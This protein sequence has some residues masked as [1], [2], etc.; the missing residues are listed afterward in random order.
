MGN[1]EIRMVIYQGDS[2][3][4]LAVIRIPLVTQG[5]DQ[6][7]IPGGI[8]LEF[9]PSYQKALNVVP[10]DGYTQDLPFFHRGQKIRVTDRFLGSLG[11]IK[12]D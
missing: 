8:G 1:Q 12:Q 6:F 3:M 7:G 4:G 2:S 10:L 5:F 11:F 9:F